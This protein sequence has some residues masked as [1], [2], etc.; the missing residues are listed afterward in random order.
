[1]DYPPLTIGVCTYKRPWYAILTLQA[2]INNII[3]Y[4]PIKFHIADGGSS[5]ED[6]NYY[7]TLLKEYQTTVEVT[8]NLAD[9]V[10]SCARYGGEY[11]LT[12]LDDFM[13]IRKINITPDVEMLARRLDIGCVRMGRLAFFGSGHINE[14]GDPEP[15]TS[16][17][18]ISHG[19]LHWWKLNK[20]K[21]KDNYT[22]SMGFHL[23]HRRFWDVYGDIHSCNPKIPGEGELNG[24]ARFNERKGPAIAIPMR[25]GQDCAEWQEP[26]WHFGVWRTDE[27]R[28][29]AGS[30]W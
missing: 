19:G 2:L 10:N 4:G 5:E 28:S 21:T 20:E 16:A 22:C 6:L 7:K 17:D 27:Y 11:W 1:M 25:F 12:V 15:E 18:L 3:Y 9:M 24:C 8:D 13:P 29:T 26:I 14:F 30:R 23:Y